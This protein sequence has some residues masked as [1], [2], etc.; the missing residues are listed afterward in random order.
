MARNFNS[1]DDLKWGQPNVEGSLNNSGIQLGTGM[2][3]TN[4]GGTA[5]SVVAPV[6]GVTTGYKISRGVVAL[7]ATG[8]TLVTASLATVVAVTITPL[9]ANFPTTNCN[10]L[11]VTLSAGGTAG[12]FTIVP[13]AATGTSDR[14][15]VV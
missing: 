12:A 9:G 5:V 10:L 13:F 6:A 1:P 2:T 4:S 7:T 3:I 11:T 14:K 8:N 15:S